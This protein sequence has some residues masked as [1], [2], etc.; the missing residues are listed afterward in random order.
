MI[1]FLS[2]FSGCFPENTG[3][4]FI[5]LGPSLLWQPQKRSNKILLQRKQE[6][7]WTSSSFTKRIQYPIW[8][9]YPILIIFLFFSSK[10]RQV[11]SKH[12]AILSI[13]HL[14]SPQ[15][16]TKKPQ[17]AHLDSTR[18]GLGGMH[19]GMH[20]NCSWISWKHTGHSWTRG[21]WVGDGR[22]R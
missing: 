2:V 15:T 12:L 13:S 14:G 4:E 20:W 6:N 11:N 16:R 10:F 5:P 18:S 3:N 8:S 1:Q 17:A 7:E 21:H 22:G 9:D 19:L